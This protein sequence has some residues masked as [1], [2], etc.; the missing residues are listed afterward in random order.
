MRRV[1]K[2]LFLLA[3]CVPRFRGKPLGI[4]KECRIPSSCSTLPA[5]EGRSFRK[6]EVLV[7]TPAPAQHRCV[8]TPQV[9]EAYAGKECD[10]RIVQASQG[11]ANLIRAG[12]ERRHNVDTIVEVRTECQR[13]SLR[14]P[15]GRPLGRSQADDWRPSGHDRQGSEGNAERDSVPNAP[16]STWT[17]QSQRLAAPNHPA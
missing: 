10:G 12:L 13:V 16:F 15:F 1:R 17:S 4:W 11:G 2:I 8:L 7:A 5:R 6:G 3:A 14:E 9:S